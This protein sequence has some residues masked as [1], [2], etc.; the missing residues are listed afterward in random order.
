MENFH[1]ARNSM[2][3]GDGR[4]QHSIISWVTRTQGQGSSLAKNEGS[5][6]QST[7]SHTDVLT[8]CGSRTGGGWQP[9]LPRSMFNRYGIDSVLDQEIAMTQLEESERL[10]KQKAE[11]SHPSA[12]PEREKQIEEKSERRESVN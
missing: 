2:S 5:L 3:Q 10:R 8:N 6:V 12:T 9:K 11:N 1:S 4:P 7:W